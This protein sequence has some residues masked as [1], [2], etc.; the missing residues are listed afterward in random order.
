MK[1]GSITHNRNLSVESKGSKE[2][3]NFS[4]SFKLSS[5]G[6]KQKKN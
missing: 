5:S 6:Q 4:D 3:A 2:K 1:V